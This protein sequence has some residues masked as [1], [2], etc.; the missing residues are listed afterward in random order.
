LF[1]SAAN[2]SDD[3]VPSAGD[4]IVFNATSTKPALVDAPKG[5]TVANMEVDADYA[6]TITLQKDLTVT[7]HLLQSGATLDGVGN[8]TIA[9]GGVYDWQGG[10]LAGTGSVTIAAGAQLH[11]A[12]AGSE[13]LTLLG[14]T[15]ENEG[16]ATWSAGDIASTGGIWDNEGGRLTSRPTST[17][18]TARERLS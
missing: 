13:P 16:E 3:T 10:T 5:G 17:G 18:W 2:W 4:T 15:I 8:L 7:D 9:D 14:R 12:A 6:S 1:S 11:I